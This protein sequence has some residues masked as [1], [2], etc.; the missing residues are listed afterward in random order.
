MYAT[1]VEKHDSIAN[2]KLHYDGWS[3][4]WDCYCD[5]QK[6]RCKFAKAGT[7]S[8]RPAHRF[9]DMKIGD[10]IDVNPSMRHPEWCLGEIRRLDP[11]SGQVQVVYEHEN[12]YFL[13]WLHLDDTKEVAPMDAKTKSISKDNAR[14]A[15]HSGLTNINTEYKCWVKSCQ[16]VLEKKKANQVYNGNGICCNSCT[17]SFSNGFIWHCPRNECISHMSGFD[18]CNNCIKLNDNSY[19]HLTHKTM[20]IVQNSLQHPK[21]WYCNTAMKYVLVGTK[22]VYNESTVSCDKC[23]NICIGYVWHCPK[24]KISVHSSGFDLCGNCAAIK[25]NDVSVV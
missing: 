2:F 5:Y 4:K 22:Q 14:L 23:G 9:K 13:Y 1:I 10:F 15:P 7:I 21:C 3:R 16:S 17:K 8:K 24:E 6:E 25:Q 12:T 19:Y 18:L 11:K 20:S